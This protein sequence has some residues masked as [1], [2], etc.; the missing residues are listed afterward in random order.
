VVPTSLL[1]VHAHPDDESLATGGTIARYAAAGVRVTL[2]TCTLGEHGEIIGEE[3]AG[4]AA[5]RADQL[6]GYRL[7]ELRSACTALGVDTH[8]FLG[9]IGRWRDSGMAGTA[10]NADPRAF[11]AGDL[12]EQAAEL[13]KII[14]EVRPDVLVSYDSGGGYGHPDHVRAHAV[15]MAAATGREHAVFCV[16]WARSTIDQGVAALAGM[17][18]MPFRLPRPGELPAL[19]DAVVTTTIDVAAYL[20]AKLAALRAHATQVAVWE[21]QD[22]QRAYALTDGVARP[23]CAVEQFALAHGRVDPAQVRTDLLGGVAGVAGV[24]GVTGVTQ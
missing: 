9:G 20:P 12:D 13:R 6:G 3:L 17:P 24:A 2:V 18:R 8:R 11:V 4:L 5:E 15:T 14:D 10:A 22:D 7:A 16:V 19:P 21:G 23:V 1:L